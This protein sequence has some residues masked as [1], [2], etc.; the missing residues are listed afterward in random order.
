MS[1]IPTSRYQFLSWIHLDGY[2][3]C[4]ALLSHVWLFATPWL[5][6]EFS[7]PEYWSGLPFPS[8][9]DLPDPGIEP[10][11]PALQSDSLPSVLPGKPLDS[12][13]KILQ[14]EWIKW[15]TFITHSSGGW[16]F[17]IKVLAYLVTY[18]SLL[19]GPSSHCSLMAEAARELSGSTFLRSPIPSMRAQSSVPSHLPKSPPP[20][21]LLIGS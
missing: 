11:S 15:Q 8:S 12:Y 10:L 2:H 7:R 3:A 5:S 18:E 6:M 13:N 21:P 19:S 14:T 1:N 4:A 16:G 17:K 20:L 9:R